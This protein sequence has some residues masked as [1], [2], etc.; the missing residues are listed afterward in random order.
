[1]AQVTGRRGLVSNDTPA[2]L[3]NAYTITKLDDVPDRA[4]LIPGAAWLAHIDVVFDTIAG[5]ATQATWYLCRDAAGDEPITDELSTTIVLGATDATDGG[6]S[7]R[8]DRPYRPIQSDLGS[9]YV[10]MKVNNGGT[11]NGTFELYW[12]E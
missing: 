12:V 1:M 2:T 9:I 4:T 10:A 11:A 8:I 3:S 7:A 6:V 5:G